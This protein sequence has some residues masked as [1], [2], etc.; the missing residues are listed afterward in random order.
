MAKS[1]QGPPKFVRDTGAVDPKL[2]EL[3]IELSKGLPTFDVPIDLIEANEWNAN[4]MDD[5]TFNR[6]VEEM[7]T[8]GMVDPIQIVPAEGGR[9]R[10]IGGEHRWQGA[11]T[12]GWDKI[13]ANILTDERFMD[14]ELQKLLS[15]RL[16]VIKGK[17]NPEKFSKLYTEMAERYGAEQLK[18][19]F[20]F[21][22]SDAWQ[23]LT[24]DLRSTL[25]KSGVNQQFLGDLD[26]KA[27]RVKTVDGLGG[28]LKNLFKKY[29]Q[30][31]QHSFMVFV[32]GGRPHLYV[33]MDDEL[34]T[35]MKKVTAICREKE[36][37]IN[38]VLVPALME[39][40]Q[41]MEDDNA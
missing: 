15:V 10:I 25:E 37:D 14:P 34:V 29:G 11:R 7:E 35:A 17:L 6:L 5:P 21:T 4:E 41:T 13:P 1:K 23:K 16:N 9:F 24:K 20:G 26:K 3:G 27:K 19:L 30:D 8:S 32:Y 28:I 12:L 22:E 33:V 36:L 40:S 39:L 2:A 31:L 38:G 18:A